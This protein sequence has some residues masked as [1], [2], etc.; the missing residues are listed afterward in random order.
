MS[1]HSLMKLI[2][3]IPS[4]KILNLHPTSKTISDTE[5]Y[6]NLKS[7]I[8]LVGKDTLRT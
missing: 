5:N 3:E 2:Y 1:M 6:S 7:C 4:N 8:N